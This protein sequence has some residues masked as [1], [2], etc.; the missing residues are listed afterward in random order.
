ME[1]KTEILTL[2]KEIEDLKNKMHY[3]AGSLETINYLLKLEE[4]DDKGNHLSHIKDMTNRITEE[5]KK[6][7]TDFN[8]LNL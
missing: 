5:I 4:D 8:Q 2:K 6:D 7:L 3:F 1:K